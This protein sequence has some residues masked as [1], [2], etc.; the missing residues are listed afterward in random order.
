MATALLPTLQSMPESA[1]SGNSSTENEDLRTRPCRRNA[2][3]LEV[4]K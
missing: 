4:I 2:V 3:I 1:T